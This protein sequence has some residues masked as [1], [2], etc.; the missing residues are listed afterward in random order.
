MIDFSEFIRR[1]Q[2]LESII[3]AFLFWLVNCFNYDSDTSFVVRIFGVITIEESNSLFSHMFF[4]NPMLDHFGERF[5]IHEFHIVYMPELLSLDNNIWR[6]TFITHSFRIG[7]M[8]FAISINFILDLWRR[9]TVT[10]FNFRWMN[11]FAF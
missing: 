4:L 7:V 6:D 5:N 10:T 2:N 9:K 3:S 1:I 11:S 8:I